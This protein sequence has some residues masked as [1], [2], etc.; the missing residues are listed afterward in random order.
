MIGQ[1]MGILSHHFCCIIR[2]GVLRSIQITTS[3][4]SQ[5]FPLSCDG[6]HHVAQFSPSMKKL[7]AK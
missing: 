5:S 2:L 4:S 7:N 3:S 6:I 1:E